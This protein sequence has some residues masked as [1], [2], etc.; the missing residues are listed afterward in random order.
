MDGGAFGDLAIDAT[1][2][3]PV[4]VLDGRACSSLSAFYDEFARAFGVE[5]HFGHNLDAM[6]NVLRGGLRAF[7]PRTSC[8]AVD[9]RGRVAPTLEPRRHG[10]VPCTP[11]DHVPSQLARNG[12]Q[13]AEP[14]E[15]GQGPEPFRYTAG[16]DSALR[17][18]RAAVSCSNPRKLKRHM[19]KSSGHV[20]AAVA[21]LFDELKQSQGRRVFGPSAPAF[22]RAAGGTGQSGIIVP[23]IRFPPVR[24][25][26]RPDDS[27][28]CFFYVEKF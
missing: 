13:R 22:L 10:I 7:V 1:G 3:V 11:A 5:E 27:H 12:A 26:A 21:R 14:S 20:A 17:R 8:A 15:A 24:P 25:H 2:Q 19:E 9:P 4:V 28:S 6:N 18:G 16:R 23:G